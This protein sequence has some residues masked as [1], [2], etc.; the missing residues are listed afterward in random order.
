MEI[1]MF[2]NEVA[3]IIGLYD[4]QLQPLAAFY[5]LDSPCGRV[6]LRF[7]HEGNLGAHLMQTIGKEQFHYQATATTAHALFEPQNLSFTWP[8]SVVGQLAINDMWFSSKREVI[9]LSGSL[10]VSDLAHAAQQV[11]SAPSAPAGQYAFAEVS[12][13]DVFVS[14]WVQ[15]ASDWW[16][17]RPTGLVRLVG[18]PGLDVKQLVTDGKIMIWVE[19]SNPVA[20]NAG[21]PYTTFSHYALYSSPYTTDPTKLERTL[22]ADDVPR[23]LSYLVLA[24]GYVVGIYLISQPVYRSAALVVRLADQQ[25]LTAV[26][27]NGYSWGYQLYPTATELWGPVTPG[28]MITFETIARFPYSALQAR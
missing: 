21:S 17:Y 15:G 24:N 16:V 1:G 25:Q 2:T 8:T 18:G 3:A 23:T 27:P 7:S 28:P 11:A 6:A 5:G 13:E 9:D 22:L 26:V 12:G 19:G 14:H 20:P 10:W 4:G